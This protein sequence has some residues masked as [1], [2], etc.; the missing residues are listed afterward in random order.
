[1]EGKNIKVYGTL[2]NHTQNTDT[3]MRDSQHNDL[4]AVAY[5]L[6]DERFNPKKGSGT[7]GAVINIDRY[8]DI[9]NKRLTAL[10]YDPNGDLTSLYS[11]L[12][13]SGDTNIGGNLHVN[14]NSTFD[15][16]ATFNSD[17][18][19]IGR[20]NLS[21]GLNDLNDVTLST[22]AIG[23]VLRYDGSKWVNAKLSIDD[24]QMPA[25]TA[26]QVLKFNGT[27]WVA[28]TDESGSSLNQPL[29]SI[30]NAG[31]SAPSAANNILMWNGS[32][33]VYTTIG[34]I[35]MTIGGTTKTLNQW[36]ADLAASAGLWTVSGSTL[37]PSDN[38]K[39]V[40]AAGFYDSTI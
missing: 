39:S 20:A 2:I 35:N 3:S 18:N 19:I 1:M 23:Q 11:D 22:M 31:L 6:F 29:S 16:P 10:S 26:G 4:I 25:A 13:V 38:T 12:Y 15:G 36:L 24:L 8:Q 30:N 17:V 27:K 21:I 5:Q 32:A 34:D 28:G 40:T 14:G 7:N 37:V 33:W 9:I